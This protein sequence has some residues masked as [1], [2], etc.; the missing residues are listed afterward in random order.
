[1]RSKED[2]FQLIQAMSKSEKRYFVLDAKKSGRTDSRYLNLFDAIND[3]EEYDEEPLKKRFAA[4]LSSDKAYLY[5]AILRSMRDYRSQSSKAAQVK[6]RLMDAR[7]LYERGLYDQ[8]TERISEAKAMAA[9]L[10]DQFTLLEINREEQVSLFDRRAKVQLEHIEKL[11]EERERTLK[12]IDEE[13]KYLDLYY[14][15]LLEVY[16]QFSLKD[17]KSI[18]MLKTKLPINLIMES[19]KPECAQALRR[20]YQCNVMYFNLIGDLDKVY[21]FSIKAVNWWDDFPALKEEEFH[22]YIINVSNLVNTCYKIEGY[23]P[24]AQEWI[25]R[26]KSEKS[27]ESTHNQKVIFQYLSLSKLL[28]HLNKNQFIE[29]SKILPEIIEGMNKF[30]L[31]RNIVLAGNIATVYFLVGDYSN[32]IKTVESITKTM[33]NSGR[34][35]IQKIVR[36]YKIISLYELDAIEKTELEIRATNRFYKTNELESG[37]FENTVLNVYLK[38][39]FN[40]TV[41][42]F[43]QNVLHLKNYLTEIK[44]SPNAEQLLG[45]DELAIWIDSKLK[46]PSY[47]Q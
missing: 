28:Y 8:S 31:K 44:Q 22:R 20:Y 30:G 17:D 33:K 1:M 47:L 23:F 11:N 37:K 18:D 42:E 2:L 27:S 38:Q 14:R 40:S 25:E 39:I 16:N 24:I 12:A 4:N 19:N 6:E 41:S 21:Q 9:E 45:L 10:E 13:L 3:M 34:I 29:A 35:D 46:K 26:L 43:K 32:C 7:F 36:L 15:L 5:E